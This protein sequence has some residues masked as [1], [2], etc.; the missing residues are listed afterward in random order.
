L[1][2]WVLEKIAAPKCTYLIIFKTKIIDG[3]MAFRQGMLQIKTLKNPNAIGS[4][5]D[6]S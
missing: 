4:A 3:F 5:S 1:D 6:K 2:I